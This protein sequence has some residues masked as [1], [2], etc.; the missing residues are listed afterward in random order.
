MISGETSCLLW[1]LMITCISFSLD[2]S[3]TCLCKEMRCYRWCWRMNE[4]FCE[5]SW[6]CNLADAGLEVHLIFFHWVYSGCPFD[7]LSANSCSI[8]FDPCSIWR[9]SCPVPNLITAL[10]CHDATNITKRDQ[11][12]GDLAVNSFEYLHTLTGTTIIH[13]LLFLFYLSFIRMHRSCWGCQ[14]LFSK[15]LAQE[16]RLG[17]QFFGR[18]LLICITVW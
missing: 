12:I 9:N 7:A 18:E 17:L 16:S 8:V 2:H 5:I 11:K 1:K 4:V 14:E 6:T 13:S 10:H 15:N 3:I